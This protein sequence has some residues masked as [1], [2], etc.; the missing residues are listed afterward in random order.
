MSG[1]G[2]IY[3]AGDIGG[4][5]S[6][7][8][9]LRGVRHGAHVEEK[10]R[11]LGEVLIGEHFYPSQKFEKFADIV[12]L[13]IDRFKPANEQVYCMCLAVAGPVDTKT[14]SAQITNVVW[15][16][17]GPALASQFRLEQVTI[18][19]DFEGIGYGLLALDNDQLEAVYT[20]SSKD[21]KKVEVDPTG[22]RAVIGA[23][24]GL[25][26]AFLTHNGREYK[27]FPCEGGHADFAPR[28]EK[29]FAILQHILKTTHHEKPHETQLIDRVSIERVASGLG[30]PKIWEYLALQRP[31]VAN[32]A[33]AALIR[34]GMAGNK[35]VDVGRVIADNAK[36][37][38]C[39][40]CVETMDLFTQSYG[41][42]AGNLC[43]KTLPFGGLYIAGGIAGK[44]MGIIRKNNQFVAN[45]LQKGRMKPVLQRIP[46]YLIKDPNVGLLGSKVICRRIIHSRAGEQPLRAKL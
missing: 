2:V 14:N 18:I 10:H 36:S 19:N 41:A 5:N 3:I 34:S 17:D 28:N 37:G 35:D 43:L 9:M 13:F 20:P 15:N 40:I 32:A 39:P 44:N 26:E 42:E 46:I 25:G 6:R 31:G 7:L 30:I 4:T 33:T 45:Y 38:A 16:I 11:G 12:K 8:Q 21:G 22:V 27:V 29:E 23:G 1:T 24:T